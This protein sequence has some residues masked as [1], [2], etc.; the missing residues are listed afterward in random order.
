MITCCLD[1][2]V[3]YELLTL[4]IYTQLRLCNYNQNPNACGRFPR[5]FPEGAS[6]RSFSVADDPNYFAFLLRL[7]NEKKA[8][9]GAWRASLEDP[10]SGERKG[11]A[12]LKD[13]YEYLVSRTKSKHPADCEEEL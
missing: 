11:F 5:D 12:N 7:W 2:A 6:R 3:P 13:L 4:G 1:L 9:S 10:H 8:G